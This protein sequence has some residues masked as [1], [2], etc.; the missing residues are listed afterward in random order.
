M[1]QV[2]N[3]SALGLCGNQF[4][5]PALHRGIGALLPP[6]G[7]WTAYSSFKRF[8]R[9]LAE[10][11]GRLSDRC[12]QRSRSDSCRCLQGRPFSPYAWARLTILLRISSLSQALSFCLG[13]KLRRCRFSVSQHVCSITIACSR[14]I[15]L[16]Y[17]AWWPGCLQNIRWEVI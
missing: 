9:L 3:N 8:S 1:G 10:R 2:N 4:A 5:H 12:R 6:R 16:L 13:T 17:C 14:H 15:R 7:S 11:C